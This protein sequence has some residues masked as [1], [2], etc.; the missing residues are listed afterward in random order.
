[1]AWAVYKFEACGTRFSGKIFHRSDR[2][3]DASYASIA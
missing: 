1:M 2:G 3:Y